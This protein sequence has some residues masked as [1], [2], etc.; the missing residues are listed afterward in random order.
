MFICS[1]T[2]RRV[3]IHSAYAG[4]S[5]LDTPEIRQAAN[6]IEI[7]DPERMPDETH[8]N[9]EIDEVPYLI[10]TPKPQEQLDQAFN[11]KV[12]AQ[13][14]AL[15]ATQDRCVREAIVSGDNTRAVALEASIAALRATLIVIPEPEPTPE[16]EPAPE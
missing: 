11:S 16:P 8:Y 7:A 2:G 14:A 13:I 15:E 4:F 9:Q 10:S 1:E 6:V 12:K 3:N 5:R